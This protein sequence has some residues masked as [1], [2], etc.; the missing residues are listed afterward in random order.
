MEKIPEDDLSCLMT[1]DEFIKS[2]DCMAFIDY[3]GYGHLATATE[4][5]D[6]IVIPSHVFTKKKRFRKKFL[7]MTE[8]FTHVVWYNR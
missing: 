3:D 4:V 2:V 6:K 8:G 7:R 1:L 5:S